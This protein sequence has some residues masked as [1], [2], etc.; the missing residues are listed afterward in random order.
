MAGGQKPLK[1]Y[2][3]DNGKTYTLIELMALCGEINR[4]TLRS[5]L[6][7]HGNNL[8]NI[9]SPVNTSKALTLSFF[10]KGRML[11]CKQLGA[12]NNVLPSTVRN[13]LTID[14]EDIDFAIL[15]AEQRKYYR[16]KKVVLIPKSKKPVIS[17]PKAVISKPLEI[18]DI[19]SD[20][21]LRN[22]RR[23]DFEERWD[24]ERLIG[25]DY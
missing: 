7:R 3:M 19:I 6:K 1:N 15:A 9:L 23:Y 17:K 2:L 18:N 5:R 22:Q 14:K 8:E 21:K 4:N 13:R 24:L 20:N 16:F 12:I 11:T 10:Y 25:F